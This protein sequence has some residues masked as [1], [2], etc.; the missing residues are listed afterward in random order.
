MQHCAYTRR[1]SGFF[2]KRSFKNCSFAD[3]SKENIHGDQIFVDWFFKPIID[4]LIGRVVLLENE[5]G[6]R[7]YLISTWKQVGT[8]R[9]TMSTSMNWIII[10]RRIFKEQFL[11]R[12]YV[13]QVELIMGQLFTCKGVIENYPSILHLFDNNSS[14]DVCSFPSEYLKL[15]N[16]YVNRD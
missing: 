4:N 5:K 13:S 2:T 12:N 6:E 1:V 9:S 8:R 7:S 10:H 11:K 15:E 3:F 14:S 16:D